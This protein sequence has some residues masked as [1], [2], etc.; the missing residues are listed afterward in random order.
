M[1]CFDYFYFLNIVYFTKSKHPNPGFMASFLTGVA[2]VVLTIGIWQSLLY[3]LLPQMPNHYYF[4]TIVACLFS[5]L[6]YRGK[7]QE[8][9]AKYE[10]CRFNKYNTRLVLIILFFIYWF[11]GVF[12]GIFMHKYIQGNLEQGSLFY[13]VFSLFRR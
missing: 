11:L 10:S 7:K 13:W 2:F 5:Y 9:C 8:I 1:F 12:C 6:R 3:L 4:V